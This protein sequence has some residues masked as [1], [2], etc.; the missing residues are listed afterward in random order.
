MLLVARPA[1][2]CNPII[3]IEDNRDEARARRAAE[4]GVY[5]HRRQRSA[6][7][8]QELRRRFPCPSSGR[9]S[10]TCLGRVVD[11]IVALK[12]CGRDTQ[13]NMA[14]QKKDA[15]QKDRWE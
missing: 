10:G 9:Y 6:R 14:W 3:G 5:C 7:A 4:S 2:A 11:H 1:V 12:R 15:R 8:K 13:G